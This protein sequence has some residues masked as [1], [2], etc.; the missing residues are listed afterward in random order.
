[1]SLE[2]EI[3]RW[4]FSSI[5]DHFQTAADAASY[6]LFIEGQHRDTNKQTDYLE[7]RQDGPSM[8]E[9]SN[10]VWIITIEVNILVTAGMDDA[11]YSK[12]HDG[13]GVTANA[14]DRTIPV[15]RYGTGANDDD[16]L[17]GCLHLDQSL[18]GDKRTVQ[19][20]HFGQINPKDMLMQATVEAMYTMTLYR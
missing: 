16:S 6:P 19:I 4:I 2:V 9:V 11:D 5:S 1:M 18:R 13:V 7:L 20:R 12:I 14:F 10:G 15:Y 17:V 8:V 3:P